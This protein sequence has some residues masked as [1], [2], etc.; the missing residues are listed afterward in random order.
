MTPAQAYDDC[1]AA[2]REGAR[3]QRVAKSKADTD[4]AAAL[5]DVAAVTLESYADMLVKMKEIRCQ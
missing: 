1:I 3:R 5:C 4:I 2:A